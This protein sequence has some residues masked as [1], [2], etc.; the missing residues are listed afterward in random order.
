[1]SRTTLRALSFGLPLGLLSAASAH[2]AEGGLVLLPSLPPFMA[3]VAEAIGAP[4]GWGT[5]LLLIFFP[6]LLLPLN[7]LLFKPLLRVLD[8]REAQIE[9]TRQRAETLERQA[10]ETLERYQASVRDTRDT[11]ERERRESLDRV[12]AEAQGETAAARADA[13]ARIESARREVEVALDS[14]RSGLRGQAEELAR[15]AASQVLGR[16]L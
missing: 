16:A 8:E 2:A 11:A 5:F 10:S 6:A 7:A 12:R 13:E 15:Q 1:M 9:G 3:S 14:A 4:V